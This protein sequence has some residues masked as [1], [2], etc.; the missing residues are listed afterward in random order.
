M[1]HQELHAEA[2]C[3]VSKIKAK[4]TVGHSIEDLEN[5]G[6]DKLVKV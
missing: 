2:S 1:T 3:D 4:T 5:T 6:S